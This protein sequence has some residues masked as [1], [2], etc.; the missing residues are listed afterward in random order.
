MRKVFLTLLL[1]I[2]AMAAHAEVTVS[3]YII[4]AH[5]GTVAVPARH[6]VAIPIIANAQPDDA[7]AVALT[8]N[9]AVYKDISAYVMDQTNLNLFEQGAQGQ[10]QGVTKQKQRG[11]KPIEFVAKVNSYGP[12]MLV[13]DNRYATIITKHVTW[14]VDIKTRLPD[15]VV[16]SLK[17][18]LQT[19]YSTL[20]KEFVFTDFNIHVRPCGMA[21]AFSSPDITICYELLD[22]LIE[23]RESE[24][25]S[26]VIV[27]ELGHS[28]MNVWGLPAYNNEDMADQFATALLLRSPNGVKSLDKAMEW[29]SQQNSLV[30]ANYMLQHGD[31]HSLS[32]QRVRNIQAY[33]A[34]PGPMEARW[35]H[36][37]YAHMTKS[38]LMNVIAH[39][40]KYDDVALAKQA[41]AVL[42][43]GK[44]MP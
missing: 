41:L 29:F 26:F 14:E 20:K 18:N 40:G 22:Q 28:L 4:T 43:T 44:S 37:F 2:G 17:T 12:Y 8:I 23:Q 19:A 36:V 1:A 38:A 25:L 13:L 21:N 30:Q 24:A 35:N 32:V 11:D 15:S 27:H 9:N 34:D 39:H 6:M 3:P 16:Q 10:I 5:N 7:I 33:I 31:P 42:D